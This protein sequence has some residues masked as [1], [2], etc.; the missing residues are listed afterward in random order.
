MVKRILTNILSNAVRYSPEGGT[1]RMDACSEEDAIILGVRV[2]DQGFSP[3]EA[4]HA[5]EP[6]TRFMRSGAEES[7]ISLGLA[8][9][10]KLAHRMGGALQIAEAAGESNWA[11]LRLPIR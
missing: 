4:A 10:T 8:M 1:I 5:D 9:A 2:S 11:E 7:E 3:N 6:S